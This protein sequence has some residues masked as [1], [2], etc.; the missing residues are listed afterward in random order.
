MTIKEM[1]P[2]NAASNQRYYTEGVTILFGDLSKEAQDRYVSFLGV[3]LD[4]EDPIAG[5]L[6]SFINDGYIKREEDA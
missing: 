1:I 5:D 2:F 6:L 4:A 3:D